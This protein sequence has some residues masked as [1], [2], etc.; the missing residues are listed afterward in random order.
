MKYFSPFRLDPSNR[1]LLRHDDRVPLTAKAFA[2]LRCLVDTP[3]RVVSKNDLMGSVWPDTHVHPDNIKVLVAEIRR[4]LGDDSARPH[5]VRSVPRQGYVFIA[6][7]ADT[8]EERDSPDVSGSPAAAPAPFVG[9]TEETR[10]LTSA[11]DAVR[12]SERRLVFVTGEAGI[13]KTALCEAFLREVGT[14]ELMRV[15]WGTCHEHSGKSELYAPLVDAVTR[16][17]RSPSGDSVTSVLR[18]HAP[19]WVASLPA[20]FGHRDAAST[21]VGGQIGAARMLREIVTALEL[22]AQEVPLVVW[23]EDVQWAD[24]ATL[25]A[26]AS[27]AHRRDPAQLLLL[28]TTRPSEFLP[29]ASPLRRVYGELLGHGRAS[30]IRLRPLTVSDVANYL[31]L[32]FGGDRFGA[33]APILHRS[34]D[35]NALF[36]IAALEYL[37]RRGYLAKGPDGWRMTVSPEGLE[38]SLP[39][40][41][42]GAVR[43][44][45]ETLDQA[46][47]RTLEIASVVGFEFG[48]W[49]AARAADEDE[50]ALEAVL[51][52]LARR[53]TFVVRDGVTQLPDHEVTPRYRFKHQLYQEIL[54]Q[55][56]AADTRARAHQRLGEAYE[57]TFTGCERDM[58]AELARHFHGAGDSARAA[59]YLRFAA[60]KAAERYALREAGALLHGALAHAGRLPAA[61]RLPIELP[62]LIELGASQAG[63][64]EG[65]LAIA[66]FSRAERLAREASQP[67]NELRALLALA[68][69]HVFTSRK[70]G[71]RYA[72]LASDLAIGVTDRTLAA[73]GA[74][75]AGMLE[76]YIGGWSDQIA[77]R[78]LHAWGTLSPDTDVD[79]RRPLGIR[80]MFVQ[81]L[82]SQYAQALTVGRKLLPMAVRSGSLTDSILCYESLVC[83]AVHVGRWADAIR[84]AA[85][86]VSL[87][88]KTGSALDAALM[89]LMQAW[90]AVETQRWDDARRLSLS[91]RA[92]LRS[93]G[94]I[95]GQQMSHVFAG[96]GAL[97]LGLLDEADEHLES[98][99]EWQARERL[100][101]DWYWKIPLHLCLTEL[102]LRRNDLDRAAAEA[103]LAR[104]AADATNERTWRG[105]ARAM[106]A[107]VAMDRGECDDVERH[108]RNARREIRG[109]DAPLAAWRIDSVMLRHL[110]RSNRVDSAHRIRARYER[111][112]QRLDLGASDI[113]GGLPDDPSRMEPGDAWTNDA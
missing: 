97:G 90:I 66:T 81:C 32:R 68:E 16:L 40:S 50:V 31:D 113:D 71:L 83:A 53:Q 35:G 75:R 2:L 76:L 100:V 65:A 109:I 77:D 24:P 69:T 43:R 110:E 107:L 49:A 52:K 102:A 96:A 26:L 56:L 1:L 12:T 38:G 47:R 112:L 60:Q 21:G 28:V 14:T 74:I 99:R 62:A 92:L 4:A 46:E 59:R 89:R 37:T 8:P 48:L 15:T 39:A 103:A 101:L 41:L 111:R 27:L 17:A 64:G 106:Q 82:R 11:F 86:G 78:C 63:L 54:Q 87:A 73:T 9:R 105:R 22:L 67:D 80:L 95:V 51:E 70:E 3:G 7:V 42:A 36:L 5:Y 25:D 84:F 57:R 33:A 72:R 61:A 19:G 30:E 104:Q 85:H 23:L 18:N 98:L 10:Q 45:A 91:G 108:L 13:G 55:G 94:W 20:V 44:Q 79:A 58:A 29:S 88:Q 93:S 6:P 34:T